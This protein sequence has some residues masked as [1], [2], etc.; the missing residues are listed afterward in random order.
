MSASGAD[1]G[2]SG[3]DGAVRAPSADVSL[4]QD[5]V[6]ASE[7]SFI[8]PSEV[9]PVLMD[10]LPTI[11]SCS[12]AV[13]PPVSVPF[14]SVPRFQVLFHVFS[15]VRCCTCPD[16]WELCFTTHSVPGLLIVPV[17]LW[18]DT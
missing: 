2:A 1:A 11:S 7:G 6:P 10:S 3:S 12:H 4:V 8:D 9:S 18:S 14:H 5:A 17:S 13:V 16:H 15:P